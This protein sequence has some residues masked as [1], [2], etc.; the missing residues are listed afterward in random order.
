MFWHKINDIGADGI[1]ILKCKGHATEADVHAGRSTEFLRKGNDHADHFAGYGVG[2]SD[3]NAPPDAA[4]AADR[5]AQ[6]WYK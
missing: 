6:R 5:E 3:A 4:K 1:S 2:I